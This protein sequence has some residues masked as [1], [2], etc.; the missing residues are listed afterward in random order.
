MNIPKKYIEPL[1]KITQLYSEIH[2]E[3]NSIESQLADI[4]VKKDKVFQDL[5]SLR[6]LEISMINKIE[7]ETGKK[8]NPEDLINLI[9]L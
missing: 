8:I 6:E 2:S 3:Y 1:I 4:I 5:K 9:D 7:D